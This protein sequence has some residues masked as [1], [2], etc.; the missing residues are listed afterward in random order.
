MKIYRDIVS[1]F[2][3]ELKT[4]IDKYSYLSEDEFWKK[5]HDKWQDNPEVFSAPRAQLRAN[6]ILKIFKIIKTDIKFQSYLDI[7]CGSGAITNTVA[8][9]L[10]IKEYHGLDI[11]RPFD[12][13][14]INYLGDHLIYYDGKNF[15]KIKVDFV[16]CFQVLHHVPNLSSMIDFINETDCKYLIIREHDVKTEEEK[17]KLDFEHFIYGKVFQENVYEDFDK[18]Y[19]SNYKSVREW[20]HLFKKFDCRLVLRKKYTIDKIVYI[21][22]KRL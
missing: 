14:Q 20:I 9:T 10:N 3:S 7:G 16:T 13:D 8:K 18:T 17:K 11:L 12:K 2:P 5:V 4:L 6:D 19:Y 21:V 1:K 15:P 22:F